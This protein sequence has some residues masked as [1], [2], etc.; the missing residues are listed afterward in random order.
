MSEEHLA[1]PWFRERAEKSLRELRRRENDLQVRLADKIERPEHIT[2]GFH[3]INHPANELVV[4]E[5]R[6]TLAHLGYADA[7][8]VLH[9]RQLYLDHIKAPRE[10]Q[11]LR[12][13]GATVDPTEPQTWRTP[14]GEFTNTDVVEAHL[15]FYA[16]RPDLLEAGLQKHRERLDDLDLALH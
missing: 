9:S 2:S 12:A 3:T 8:R 1:A 10:P 11:I 6:Q 14:R 15:R 5:A 13:L 7:D 16:D 4:E